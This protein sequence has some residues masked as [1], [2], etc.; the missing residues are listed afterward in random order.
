MRFINWRFAVELENLS[1][2]ELK[3]E[4]TRM[5][6]LPAKKSFVVIAAPLMASYPM[7]SKYDWQVVLSVIEFKLVPSAPTYQ[8]SNGFQDQSP[9]LEE[10]S[11]TSDQAKHEANHREEDTNLSAED[12]L[13]EY[14]THVPDDLAKRVL[15]TI[16]SFEKEE[17]K[18]VY[19][20]LARSFHPDSSQLPG[21]QSNRLFAILSNAFDDVDSVHEGWGSSYGNYAVAEKIELDLED[22]D[23]EF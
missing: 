15:S 12:Y 21:E 23:S 17:L 4:F 7:R 5:T 9:P 1:L 8:F 11:Q 20:S 19:R 14:M 13:A 18:P 22:F 3:A 6:G 10:H 2:K 16:L